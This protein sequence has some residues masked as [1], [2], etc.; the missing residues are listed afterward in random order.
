MTDC[1]ACLVARENPETGRLENDCRG[2]DVRLASC[3]PR[4]IRGRMVQEVRERDGDAAADRY[5]ADVVDEFNRRQ[6][7]R[8]TRAPA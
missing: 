1:P 2:C 5:L 6:A 4:E 7:W 3:S 8:R